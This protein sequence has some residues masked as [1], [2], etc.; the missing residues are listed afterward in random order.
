VHDR[1]LPTLGGGLQSLRWRRLR[2]RG[3]AGGRG[4]YR[5]GEEGGGRELDGLWLGVGGHG[6]RLGAQAGE[7]EPFE[8]SPAFSFQHVSVDDRLIASNFA[9]SQLFPKLPSP[10]PTRLPFLLH[11]SIRQ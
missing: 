9:P 11:V 1:T 5:E 2:R 7:G 10:A 8:L 4:A 3:G 6:R